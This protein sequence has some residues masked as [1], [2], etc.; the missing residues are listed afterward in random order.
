MTA[1]IATA[2]L[3]ALFLVAGCKGD[4]ALPK[5]YAVTGKVVHADGTPVAGGLVHFK[6]QGDD[7]VTTSGMIGTDGSF[8]LS[9]LIDGQKVSGATEGPHT[10]TVL[11]PQEQDRGAARGRS[12]QP[13]ELRDTFTVKADGE[14]HFTIT[15]PKGR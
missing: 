15:L 1:R 5:T 9:T 13:V 12:A 2:A 10:V 4:K 11:P 6:P 3:A 14:N 7:A 8:T